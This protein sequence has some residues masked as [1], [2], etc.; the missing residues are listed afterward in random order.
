MFESFARGLV[1][2]SRSWA[3]LLVLT[4]ASIFFALPV[5]A[6]LFILI[7]QTSAGTH[8]P[9]RMMSDRIDPIWLI[10][11]F[12]ERLAGASLL[13]MISQAAIL[14]GVMAFFFLI[15]NV[16]FAGGILG[17]FSHPDGRFSHAR[18]WAGAGRYFP[19]FLRLWLLSL[20]VY[21]LAIAGYLLALI[22][23]NASDARASAERPGAIR[24]W[25]A[26]A[27]LLLA[28][29]VINLIFDYAR[30][31]A[32]LGDRARM[33]A[34]VFRAARFSF[35]HFRRTFGLYILLSFV[36]MCVFGVIVGIRGAVE[37]NTPFAVFAAVVLGQLAIG[38]RWWSRLSFYSAQ[39]DLYRRLEPS[40]DISAMRDAAQ[41]VFAKAVDT[42]ELRAPSSY[43]EKEE[44]M[45]P[46]E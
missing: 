22:P 37:Q 25:A 15:A 43:E 44:T 9:Y 7:A 36:G 45:E 34:E 26:A 10:D 13:T 21:G 42:S 29:S 5:A 2:A 23:I 6:P 32:V 41:P 39:L 4:A 11:L 17:V 40:S 30:I 18:F 20:V 24:Q 3:M 27:V 1:Q 12:N 14:T 8:A 46:T 35:G 28:L 31:G 16:L 33:F 19:R 38:A